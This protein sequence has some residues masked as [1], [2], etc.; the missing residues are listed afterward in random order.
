MH[1]I[2]QK[3]HIFLDKPTIFFVIEFQNYGGSMT[4]VF[5][6][7]KIDSYMELI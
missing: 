3:A 4:I 2:Q 7:L 6:G 1:N 5:Y